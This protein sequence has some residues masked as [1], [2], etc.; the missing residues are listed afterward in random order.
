MN[1][2]RDFDNDQRTF[3]YGEG[4]RFLQRL[5]DRGQHYVPIVD[6][7][8]YVPNPENAS[9]AYAP[10]EEGNKTGV[11]LKNP[12]GTLYVGAVWPGYTSFIDFR[13]ETTDEWWTHQ[14]VNYHNKISY[15]GIWIDMNEASSFCKGS[16]GSNN[17]TLNPVHPPFKRK[18]DV[19]SFN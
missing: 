4:Q 19:E 3:P 12:D 13:A 1:Q 18:V 7:A 9:D 5:H 6:A 2:Y 14:F 11:F 15:D 17:I 8:I 16:C 10:F